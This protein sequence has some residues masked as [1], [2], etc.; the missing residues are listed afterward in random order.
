MNNKPEMITYAIPHGMR[1]GDFMWYALDQ[2]YRPCRVLDV[3]SPH[4]L[5]IRRWRWADWFAYGWWTI[6]N[7]AIDKWWALVD[8]IEEWRSR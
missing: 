3:I 7:A 2:K 6:K 5:L 1:R 8:R 4:T